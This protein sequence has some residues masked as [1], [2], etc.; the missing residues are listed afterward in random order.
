MSI[1]TEIKKR[2]EEMESKIEDFHKKLLNNPGEKQTTLI[3]NSIELLELKIERIKK[4]F[5]EKPGPK[6]K[7]NPA[8]IPL[9]IAIFGG[10]ISITLG[11]Y[12]NIATSDLKRQENEKELMLQLMKSNDLAQLKTNLI[13]FKSLGFFEKL[14]M[15]ELKELQ[16][17]ELPYFSKFSMF[18]KQVADSFKIDSPIIG[19][20]LDAT[21][22]IYTVNGSLKTVLPDGYEVWV[23]ARLPTG[24]SIIPINKASVSPGR[25]KWNASCLITYT[26]RIRLELLLLTKEGGLLLGDKI[27]TSG[28]SNVLPSDLK[29]ESYCL[30]YVDIVRP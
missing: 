20:T 5:E 19:D 16:L 26:G 25:G 30:E 2:V 15:K 21:T 29:G 11:V 1:D 13:F 17:N 9:W 14:N 3:L 23:F 10:L 22:T 6:R 28:Y 4:E 8:M 12:N 24:T 18:G 7:I 27:K